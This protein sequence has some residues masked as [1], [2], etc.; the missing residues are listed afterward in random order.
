[1]LF[2]YQRK[3]YD[4][5]RWLHVILPKYYYYSLTP[6]PVDSPVQGRDPVAA[7]VRVHVDGVDVEACVDEGADDVV[8]AAVGRQVERGLLVNVGL[9]GD[10]Q[11]AA[12]LSVES[13]IFL[14]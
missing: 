4:Q 3:L 6:I 10:G 9:V 2:I 12:Y 5:P 11:V 14:L 1:M 13:Y 8:V 7:P